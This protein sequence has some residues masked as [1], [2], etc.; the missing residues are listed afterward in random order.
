MN[1]MS[2][3]GLSFFFKYNLFTD[4]KFRL[5]RKMTVYCHFFYITEHFCLDKIVIFLHILYIFVGQNC[6]FSIQSIHFC[7]DKMVI[8]P[9]NLYIFVWIKWSFFHTIYTFLFG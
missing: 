4:K 8:F 9:C 5:Y 7:M 1:L 3:N 6:H 2:I